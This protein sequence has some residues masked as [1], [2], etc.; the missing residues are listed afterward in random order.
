[1]AAGVDTERDRTLEHLVRAC[2][3]V[4]G[5]SSMLLAAVAT[6]RFAAGHAN[7][8]LVIAVWAVPLLNLAWSFITAHHDR[9]RADL[10]R[11]LACIPL[12][13]FIYAE[14]T[15]G[16]LRHLWLPAMI[17]CVATCLAAG[18]GTRR[19]RTGFTLAFGYAAG[20]TIAWAL[21]H[22]EIDGAVLRDA[23]GLC[24]TGVILTLVAAHLGRSLDVATQQRDE[25]TEQRA[26]AEVTLG[27]L[28]VALANVQ[29]EM[30]RRTAVEA[31]LVQAQKLESVGRLAAGIAHEINT[32]VQFVGDSISFLR[33]AV[34][35][36]FDVVRRDDAAERAAAADAADLPFLSE[37]V[38]K[39]LERAQDGLSRVSTIV[40][41]MKAFAHPDGADMAPID[42]NQA[43][44]ATLIIASNEYKYVA[45]LV[46]DFAQLPCVSCFASEINQ[47][48][49]NIVV[50]A[51]HAIADVVGDSGARGTLRVATRQIGGEIEIAISDTGTGI[52][53]VHRTRIFD[54]FFTT[55]DIGRGTGQGLAIAR[56]VVVDKHHGKL[57]FETELGRGTTFFIRLPI[58]GDSVE[59]RDVA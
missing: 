6:W 12:T 34:S 22:H 59:M 38:P 2:D 19:A 5:S 51:G 7:L 53:E 14:T 55:K 42:L 43:I 28:T 8:A 47:V 56:H 39:A 25:A 26:R 15:T 48:V 29:R 30:E 44:Q 50:N 45:D 32:P 54:P 35:D 57:T 41:S 4:F 24:L 9:V 21:A 18:I 16:M 17:V 20:I 31:E 3:V 46:T 23:F 52:P 36:L 13:S 11:G 1:M 49:L 58:G 37:E 40:R 10:I 27:Q 33:T